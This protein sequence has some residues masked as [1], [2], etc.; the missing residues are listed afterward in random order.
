MSYLGHHMHLVHDILASFS[1]SFGNST[2]VSLTCELY[3]ILY[4]TSFQGTPS[5]VGGLFKVQVTVRGVQY[6]I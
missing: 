6:H 4:A 3:L 5:A 2:K 1:V